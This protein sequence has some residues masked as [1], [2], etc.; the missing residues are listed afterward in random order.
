M[1]PNDSFYL[2]YVS[3]YTDVTGYNK[4]DPLM[5][6]LTWKITIINLILSSKG[7]TGIKKELL[8]KYKISVRD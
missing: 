6:S 2:H 4:Y 7:W 1:V 3:E 5:L 8:I